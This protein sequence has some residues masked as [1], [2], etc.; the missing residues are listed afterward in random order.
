MQGG[1]VAFSAEALTKAAVT[2]ECGTVVAMNM[3]PPGTAAGINWLS[4][5][6]CLQPE[7]ARTWHLLW[8][9]LCL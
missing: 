2:L 8:A 6:S 1:L 4:R 7:K 5:G 9:D 3:T